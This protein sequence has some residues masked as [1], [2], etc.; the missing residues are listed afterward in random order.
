MFSSSPI[1]SWDD[2]GVFYSFAGSAMTDMWFWIAV[3]CCVVPL[4]VT[5]KT[6][7]HHEVKHGSGGSDDSDHTA[8]VQK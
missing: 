3:L 4:Y 1:E 5:L 8:G 2:A 7:N 6:E